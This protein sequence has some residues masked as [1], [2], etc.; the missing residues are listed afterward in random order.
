MSP[1]KIV[2]RIDWDSLVRGWPVDDEV[3]EIA[4][5]GPVP[6]SVVAAMIGSGDTFLAAVVTKGTDV[7][8]VAHLGRR[9]TAFQRSALDWLNPTCT[10]WGCNCAVRLQIDHREDWADTRITLLS[11]LDDLC[12]HHHSLKT[13]KQWALVAGTGKRPMV[14]PDDPRHPKNT[15][16]GP[17]PPSAFEVA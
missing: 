17:A 16:A 13:Y 2:V 10:V 8:N 7:V 6:V 4:G 1:A 11:L 9:P 5:L 14:P 3:C 15:R 12:K